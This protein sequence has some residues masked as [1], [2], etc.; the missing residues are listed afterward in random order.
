ML[1]V[2]GRAVGGQW[3]DKEGG[4]QHCDLQHLVAIWV[5]F[6][7]SPCC[8]TV[9][10][11]DSNTEFQVQRPSH[12]SSIDEGVSGAIGSDRYPGKR[13]KVI[14]VRFSI[15]I[16]LSH[17]PNKSIGQDTLLFRRLIY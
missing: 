1:W 16:F 14:Y 2:K 13:S 15:R 12:R 5:E 11:V 17:S 8:T 4:L 3:L 7:V 6:A 10:N 9:K